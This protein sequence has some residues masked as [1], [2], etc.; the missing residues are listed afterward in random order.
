MYLARVRDGHHNGALKSRQLEQNLFCWGE[1][2]QHLKHR[3]EVDGLRKL[4]R[5][6]QHIEDARVDA[7]SAS[8]LHRL[9]RNVNSNAPDATSFV[10]R[11]EKRTRATPH[12]EHERVVGDESTANAHQLGMRHVRTAVLD[13][14]PPVTA[15]IHGGRDR[16]GVR[17]YV[18]TQIND[19]P[20]RGAHTQRNDSSIPPT[21]NCPPTLIVCCDIAMRF[22]IFHPLTGHLWRGI[23]RTV[24]GLSSALAEQEHDVAVLTIRHPEQAL[25][26]ELGPRVRLIQMPNSRYYAYTTAI[27]AFTAHLALHRYDAVIAFFGGFGVGP[28]ISIARR[29]APV[30]LFLCPCYPVEIASHRY[31]EIERYQLEKVAIGLWAAGKLVASQAA[32]RWNRNVIALPQG[33][34]AKRFIPDAES[35]ANMR[36]RMSIAPSAPLLL[37]VS[38]LD[39]RKG[40]QYVLDA[41]PRVW[42]HRPDLVYV[43]AGEGQYGPTLRS[44]A[45]ALD[46]DVRFLGAVA[47]VES[48]YQA[49]DLFCLLSRGEANPMVM[50]EAMASGLP[51]VTSS[52]P[53]FPEI[54]D[55]SVADL[56]AGTDPA[57][58]SDAILRLIQNP[59]RRAEMGFAARALA[60]SHY[61]FDALARIVARLVK[62]STHARAGSLPSG[63]A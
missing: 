39:E 42:H 4:Q 55:Q 18:P 56:V 2:L 19:P 33:V 62:E 16:S 13:A 14:P 32:A 53:P 40:I 47:G 11:G 28:S 48:L 38:A 41:L 43:V 44:Q 7:I 35:G 8:L 30:P 6:A 61:S 63:Q 54:L 51:Q 10:K 57:T 9:L 26:G 45:L 49:A 52:E 12:I 1:M 31:K 58:I 20:R 15:V 36:R 34:D 24:I 60:E 22:L 23:E 46:G 59:R 50:Y 17:P 21:H 3:D 37:T 25:L 5:L 27:A 29:L